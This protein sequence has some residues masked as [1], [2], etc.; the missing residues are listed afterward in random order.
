MTN[1]FELADDSREKLI[2]EKSDLLAPLLPGMQAPP[3]AM[4]PGSTEQDYY[5]N[6]VTSTGI[7]EQEA[8]S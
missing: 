5:A 6:R 4:V 3:H 2:F 8:T 7:R 1:E